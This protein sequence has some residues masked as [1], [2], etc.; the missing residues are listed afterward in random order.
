MQIAN[1]EKRTSKNV[2]K[3]FFNKINFILF[4]SH[5]KG[6]LSTLGLN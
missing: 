2:K 4:Y 1:A 3:S 6:Q 5:Q